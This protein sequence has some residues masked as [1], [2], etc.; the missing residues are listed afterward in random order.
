MKRLVL[1][2][3]LVMLLTG[4][5][6]PASAQT[7]DRPGVVAFG[8]DVIIRTGEVVTGDVVA[9]G[10]DV[11]IEA[12]ARVNGDI[13][14]I[15]GDVTTAANTSLYGDIVA[16]GGSIS[17]AGDVDGSIV[18]IGGDADLRAGSLVRKDAIT[19]GGSVRQADGAR[20]QGSV[21]RGFTFDLGN[22]SP[23]SRPFPLQPVAPTYRGPWSADVALSILMGLVIAVLKIVVLAALAVVV[24]AIFPRQIAGVKATMLALPGESA[25][26]GCLTYLVAI[27]LTIPLVLTCIGNFLMWPALI[28][29]TTFGIGALGLIVG[30]RLAGTGGA[31][32]RSPAFNAAL[33]TGL[34]LLVLLT[35]DAVPFVAC[36]A[37]VFW[38]LVASL[39]TGAVV[40]SK[41][42][43]QLP[44]LV[45]AVPIT[46]AAGI[47]AAA[48]APQSESIGEPPKED[49]Q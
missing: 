38:L 27:A 11:T 12:G 13:V 30:E 25:G 8:R 18:A 49:G 17:S 24:V 41:F 20:V 15:G 10:G 46:P 32:P 31:Q 42:G 3:A 2:L 35:L 5:A 23:N 39:T 34:L 47:T 48:A 4:M 22:G 7:N 43:T 21:S 44:P 9:L 19:F 14:A 16:V 29:A 40:L 26:V 28:I 37:W 33:G 36:F 45:P 1:T 6:A